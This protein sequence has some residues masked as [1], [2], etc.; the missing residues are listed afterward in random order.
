M[1]I[2]PFIQ[3]RIERC[4]A[5]LEG[6]AYPI[7][8]EARTH[9]AI[10][11]MGTIGAIWGLRADGS[12]WHFDEDWGLP[13]SPLPNELELQA[14]V[15]GVDRH[16][17][18]QELLPVRS[19]NARNCSHCAGRGRLAEVSICPICHGLGWVP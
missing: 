9:G 12:V 13:L 17:W 18:L 14:L 5:G 3:A 10:A 4:I 7:D 19:A 15:F 6:P 1:N 11:L 16:P 2:P 8:E